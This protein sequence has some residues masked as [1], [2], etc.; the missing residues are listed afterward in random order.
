MPTIFT[1]RDQH[2]MLCGG[3]EKLM[4][5]LDY[6]S[7]SSVLFLD[8]NNKNAV[9]A[10]MAAHAATSGLIHEEDKFKEAIFV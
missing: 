1:K 9:L 6:L 10:A 2:S 3:R 5:I 7:E 8:D 4:R